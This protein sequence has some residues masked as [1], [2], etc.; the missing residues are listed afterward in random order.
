MIFSNDKAL[1]TAK[2]YQ[3]RFWFY[4]FSTNTEHSPISTS[5]NPTWGQL[6]LLTI[7]PSLELAQTLS[8]CPARQG[9]SRGVPLHVTLHKAEV[10]PE[11][12]GISASCTT[13]AHWSSPEQ[14]SHTFHGEAPVWKEIQQ[15]S[16]VGTVYCK[17]YLFSLESTMPEW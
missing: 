9:I 5:L 17:G 10:N 16:A 11:H 12:L 4:L 1:T 13:L 3:V 7:S 14:W 2:H 15:R 6:M 8:T